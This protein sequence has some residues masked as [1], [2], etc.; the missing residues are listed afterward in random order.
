MRLFVA[1]LTFFAIA[2]T[3]SASD[4]KRPPQTTAPAEYK[5]GKRA[6]PTVTITGGPASNWFPSA[7]SNAPK[8]TGSTF[9]LVAGD[10]STGG[11]DIYVGDDLRKSFDKV[12]E[13]K[14]SD[15]RSAD[16]HKECQALFKKTDVDLQKRFFG[17]IAATSV[18]LRPII[19]GAI[20]GVIVG[21]IINGNK[22]QKTP[23]NW[24]VPEE[25][26][27]PLQ[28]SPTASAIAIA[29]A[30]NDPNPLVIAVPGEDK[31]KDAPF[32]NGESNGDYIINLDKD[33]ATRLDDLL[34]M[35]TANCPQPTKR[36]LNALEKRV[37]LPPEIVACLTAGMVILFRNIYQGPLG[38]MARLR[39]RGQVAARPAEAG[40]LIALANAG[41]Q[42]A[43]F[44]RPMGLNDEEWRAL[45]L[46]VY[47]EVY[48]REV[49]RQHDGALVRIKKEQQDQ[50][51]QKFCPPKDLIRCV[52]DSCK[53]KDGRCAE[54]AQ[55]FPKCECTDDANCP[56]A[57][58]TPFC[59]NCG[60]DKGGSKCKGINDQTWKDCNC[61]ISTKK[62][63]GLRYFS[64]RD[65][66]D[67]TQKLFDD[68]PM[69][70]DDPNPN[71]PHCELRKRIDGIVNVE[72][73][74]FKS[75][76]KNAVCKGFPFDIT[77]SFDH[78]FTKDNASKDDGNWDGYKD[79]KF[80]FKWDDKPN[81]CVDT[82]A[83]VYNSFA[84]DP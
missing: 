31:P 3:V 27:A 30:T 69:L 4:I 22:N 39:Q 38:E 55:Y 70:P 78:T 83:T 58:L 47:W 24:H 67:Q 16:C 76:V 33:L 51:D 35:N 75:L 20:I 6:D 46:G 64:N 81:T 82:C 71:L 5:H 15:P 44:Q 8:P 40:A 59:D 79:W 45:T 54:D 28:A 17:L 34:A 19:I 25:Q 49:A 21:V 13:E 11:F 56:R 57:D 73:G 72:T 36:N 61:L 9:S 50:T 43:Q 42:V 14:C 1:S 29:S 63:K 60:G 52:S 41:Q 37:D 62:S 65:E 10:P 12:L 84:D 26:A 80:Q 2:K 66:F 32:I 7:A 74:L 23:A 18:A 53:G 48:N 68:L 77:S